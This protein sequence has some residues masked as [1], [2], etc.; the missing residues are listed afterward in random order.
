MTHL[1]Q[2]NTTM[3]GTYILEDNQP[4]QPE[5]AL[6]NCADTTMLGHL[7]SMFQD[8]PHV[9]FFLLHEMDEN[10]VDLADEFHFVKNE[11]TWM[12]ANND[13][14]LEVFFDDASFNPEGSEGVFSLDRSDDGSWII[15]VGQSASAENMPADDP[16]L[17]STVEDD[18]FT[19]RNVMEESSD[20]ELFFVDPSVLAN[21]ENEIVFSNFTVGSDL[22]EL[23]E[24]L[25]VKDVIVYDEQELTEVVIGRSDE[26][27]DD[28]VV[29]LL[30][31]SQSDLPTYEFGVDGDRAAD[32][33]I[34]HLIQSSLN[35][36]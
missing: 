18:I 7:V 27:A 26:P 22:L 14:I 3:L 30:G 31:V 6:A 25:S 10:A 2:T 29:K 13:S 16:P 23:R 36:D 35:A 32:D 9:H 28:I 1:A 11:G 17:V 12:L 4:S 24:G 34:N 33:L 21:G 20:S 15:L 8:N 5:I 19:D